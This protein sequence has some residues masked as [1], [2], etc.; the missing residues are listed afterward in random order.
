MTDTLNDM[1]LLGG[2][3]TGI[4]LGFLVAA[5]GIYRR[6][7][8]PKATAFFQ[9]ITVAP[10]VLVGLS[11]TWLGLVFLLGLRESAGLPVLW[12]ALIF[13]VSLFWFIWAMNVYA[14][15]YFLRG[16]ADG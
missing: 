8:I 12:L 7:A 9:L 3:L 14:L 16:E 5:Y 4:G 11:A 2:L 13:A 1:A 10:S 6:H 15:Y